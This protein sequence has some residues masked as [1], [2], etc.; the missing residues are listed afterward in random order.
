MNDKL[1]L[2]ILCL[3]IIGIEGCANNA[4]LVPPMKVTCKGKGN[5]TGTGNTTVMMG[6]ASNTFTVQADCGSDGFY[7]EKE[8]V[9]NGKG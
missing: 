1:M 6:S 4:Q 8:I 3:T 9:T 7:F 5:I 2:I